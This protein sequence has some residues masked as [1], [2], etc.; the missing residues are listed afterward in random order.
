[1]KTVGDMLTRVSAELGELESAMRASIPNQN[2]S[3][4]LASGRRKLEQAAQH[5]DA[6]TELGNLERKEP[7]FPFKGTFGSEPGGAA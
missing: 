2:I 7:E 6:A 5:A 4:V 3:D 1:M